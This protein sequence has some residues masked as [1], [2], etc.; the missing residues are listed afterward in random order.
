MEIQE[1]ERQGMEG[2]RK[3]EELERE[4]V[5]QREEKWE[6]IRFSRW[7]GCV[8]EEGVLKYLEKGWGDSRWQRIARFRL[9]NEMMERRY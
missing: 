4:K 3:Y 6:Q 1:W 9:G 7:Y 2:D 5:R 8:K